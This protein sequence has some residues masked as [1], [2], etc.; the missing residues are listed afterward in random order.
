[1]LTPEMTDIMDLRRERLFGHHLGRKN[2]SLA[3]LRELARKLAIHLHIGS[4]ALK[5]SPERASFAR[6]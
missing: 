4:L 6:S 5:I 1:M 3:G 2:I